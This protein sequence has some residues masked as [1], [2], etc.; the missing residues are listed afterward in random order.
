M[1]IA[2]F[3][4]VHTPPLEAKL[5]K[6]KKKKLTATNQIEPRILYTRQTSLD[7]RRVW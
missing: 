6:K 4:P 3:F 7:F 5:K 1:A 2:T